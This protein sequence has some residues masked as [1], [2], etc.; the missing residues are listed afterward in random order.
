MKKLFITTLILFGFI[1]STTDVLATW[2]HS[3]I[4][5][6]ILY[7]NYIFTK[8]LK[9]DW[10]FSCLIEGTQ[11]P[12]LFDTGFRE[13]T[14]RHNI[15]ILNKD[16]NSVRHVVIS[17]DHYDHTGNLLAF[18]KENN[19]TVVYLPASLQDDLYLKEIKATNAMVTPVLNPIEICQGVFLTGEMDSP[20]IKEQ[21][22]IIDTDRGLI[23]IAGCA[24]PGIINIVRKAKNLLDKDIYLLIGGFHLLNESKINIVHLIGQLKKLGVLNIGPTHCTGDKAIALF[25]KEYGE[26][27]IQT[28]VGKTL[29]LIRH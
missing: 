18:L 6:T 17:H 15:S 9:A 23:L 8:G 27:Y 24:H 12:V 28:G 7:D 20:V 2:R 21:S 25:K 14:F 26:N 29:E 1:I 5:I 13:D 4:S 16:L 19:N 11:E 10:G 3:S 22:M